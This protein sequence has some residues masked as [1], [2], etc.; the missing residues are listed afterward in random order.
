MKKANKQVKQ[1]PKYQLTKQYIASR[2]GGEL[3]F[4]SN[5]ILCVGIICLS[6]SIISLP[7]SLL[8]LPVGGFL[9]YLIIKKR[10]EKAKIAN[11]ISYRIIRTTCIDCYE[12]SETHD[13]YFV[14]T[15]CQR[16]TYEPE[17][18]ITTSNREAKPGDIVYLVH[19]KEPHEIKIFFNENKFTP[20]PDLV[21]EEML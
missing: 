18:G 9:I 19:A 10:N 5:I 14:T 16:F 12:H 13:D 17:H 21:I 3:S 8:L 20:A 6:A 15:Y 7:F 2:L 11:S 1:R 4:F